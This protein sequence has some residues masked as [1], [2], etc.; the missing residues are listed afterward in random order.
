[1]SDLPTDAELLAFVE[2]MLP[3]QRATAVEQQLRES[4]ELR[5]RA[6]ELIRVRDQGGRTVGEIWRRHRLSCPSRSELSSL[7]LGV[8]DSELA[9]YIGFHIEQVGCRVCEANLEDLQEAH[10]ALQQ[11]A[12]PASRQE[13]IF[14]SSAGI[15]RDRSRRD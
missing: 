4:S 2:E 11:S 7:V 10:A 3:A 12:P 1:M 8:L 14:E 15:L 5:E 13:R 9:D 6:A